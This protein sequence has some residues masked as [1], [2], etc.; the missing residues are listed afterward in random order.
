MQHWYSMRVVIKIITKKCYNRHIYLVMGDNES[1]NDIDS[2]F[3]R[4]W[5]GEI[6]VVNLR[7]DWPRDG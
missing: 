5:T 1:P 2:I 6:V 4:L 7:N 3:E